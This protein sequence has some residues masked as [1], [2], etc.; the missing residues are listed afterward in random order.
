M[1]ALC[2]H[3]DEINGGWLMCGATVLPCRALGLS[4][5]AASAWSV[6]HAIGRGKSFQDT[7]GSGQDITVH[8]IALHGGRAYE[9]R[10]HSLYSKG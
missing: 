5:R 7:G 8:Q 4:S 6:R 3:L 1:Q 2:L 10:R 9:I